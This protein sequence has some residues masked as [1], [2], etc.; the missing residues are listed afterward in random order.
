LEK[1][2]ATADWAKWIGPHYSGIAAFLGAAVAMIV[3]SLLKP[4]G[5]GLTNIGGA[6]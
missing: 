4:M 2:P 5:D 6:R 3:G 1:I